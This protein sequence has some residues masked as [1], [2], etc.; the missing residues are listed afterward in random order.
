MCAIAKRVILQ[1]VVK[2]WGHAWSIVSADGGKDF[3]GPALNAC[4]HSC[5]DG[6]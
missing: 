3:I 1:V 6:M 4:Q 2:E 5:T